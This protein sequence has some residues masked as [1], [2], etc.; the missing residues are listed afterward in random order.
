MHFKG[1]DLNL[2]VAL[3]ALLEEQNV[4][5][6]GERVHLSQS[7][8]SGALARLREHYQDPLLVQVGRKLKLTE[9]AESLVQPVRAILL[10]IEVTMN[11]TPAFDPGR[12]T[13]AFVVMASDYGS[14][15]LISEALRRLEKAAP[16]ITVEIRPFSDTPLESLERGDVDLLVMA[17]DFLSEDHPIAPLFSDRFVCV[18][19]SKNLLIEGNISVE[20]FVN[21]GHVVV[22]YGRK[23]I[24][25]I[26][27]KF[28]ESRGYVRRVEVVVGSFSAVP[29]FLVETDRIAVMHERL[30]K[31]YAKVMPLKL[32][33]PPI[34][35]PSL[36]QAMQWHTYRDKDPASIW[37][38]G[39]LAQISAGFA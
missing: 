28:F 26:Q 34:D 25:H 20:Q 12:S 29:H 35:M 8:M 16:H 32:L 21:L 5:R 38:R 24:A 27:E 14:I 31:E 17:R 11:P 9:L 1:L 37:F 13:R 33:S 36:N 22:K 6:A 18:A 39:Q 10:Q 23:G 19:W 4:S 3:D 30:A 7:A 15:V 2:L